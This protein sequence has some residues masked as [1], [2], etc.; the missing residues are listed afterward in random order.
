M[1]LKVLPGVRIYQIECDSLFF[2]TPKAFEHNLPISPCLGDFKNV[3]SDEIISF[4]SL[5]QKQYC[6]NTV[7]SEKVHSIFKVSGL[8]LK[9]ELNSQRLSE[10]SFKFFLDK[11]I[12]GQNTSTL[13]LQNK[14]K[15]D[16]INLRVISYQEKFTLTN[17]LCCKRL[18]NVYDDRLTTFPFG[19]NFN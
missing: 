4:Y 5:G 1:D 15:S 16:F 7:S 2:S 12:Q 19:Y 9:S 8:S 10:N 17:K 18:V 13:F 11:F 14:F 6:I 3:Y